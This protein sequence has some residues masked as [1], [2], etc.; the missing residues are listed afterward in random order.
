MGNILKMDKIKVLDRL[1]ES[2]WT[3]RKIN[4]ATGINRRT[5]SKYRTKWKDEERSKPVSDDRNDHKRD[6]G[7]EVKDL[8]QNTPLDGVNKRPPTPG[9]FPVNH[10]KVKYLF[11]I[12][13][14]RIN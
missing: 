1:Y 14:S 9:H 11:L 3:D 12:S 7:N 13:R 6:H 5:I 2:G 4:R 10:P 8:N